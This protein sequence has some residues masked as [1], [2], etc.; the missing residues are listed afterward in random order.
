MATNNE[1]N[2]YPNLGPVT[3]F[4]FPFL[5][6]TFNFF[7]LTF[8]FFLFSLFKTASSPLSQTGSIHYL[9]I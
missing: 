4:S 5:L 7:L 2:E 1:F 3:F 6:I 8:N 9:S